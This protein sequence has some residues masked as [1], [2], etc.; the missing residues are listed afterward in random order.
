MRKG[1]HD[2]AAGESIER[3][4]DERFISGRSVYGLESVRR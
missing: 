4:K 1:T 3:E 2:L